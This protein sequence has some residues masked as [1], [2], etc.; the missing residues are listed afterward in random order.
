MEICNKCKYK[1]RLTKNVEICDKC[2]RDNMFEFGLKSYEVEKIISRGYNAM[3]YYEES[4]KVRLKVQNKQEMINGTG[5]REGK[6]G[7]RKMVV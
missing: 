2:G 4:E 3:K 7:L 5:F 6:K 1:I